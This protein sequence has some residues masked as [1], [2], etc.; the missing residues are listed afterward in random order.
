MKGTPW[1][2]SLNWLLV[3]SYGMNL[4]LCCWPDISKGSWCS[5]F[6]DNGQLDP[7]CA[8]IFEKCC[9]LQIEPL[10]DAVNHG[11]TNS[12]DHCARIMVSK[13]EGCGV[14]L[15]ISAIRSMRFSDVLLPEEYWTLDLLCFLRCSIYWWIK[16][17]AALLLKIARK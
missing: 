11:W 16:C 12:C 17:V 6:S 15:M 7:I 5:L 2:L 13:T 3:C 4:L 14:L 10:A 9:M 1:C 8:L